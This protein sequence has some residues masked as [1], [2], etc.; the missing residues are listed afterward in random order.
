MFWTLLLAHL[1]GDFVFQTDWMVKKRD[2]FWVLTLH[3]MIHFVTMFIVVGWVRFAIWPYLLLIA[4]WH[5]IQDR[6]KNYFTHKRPT[7]IGM[8]F[9][10]DQG[11]HIFVIWAVIG[12]YQEV[13][14]SIAATDKPRWVMIAITYV[15]ITFV[16]FIIERIFNFSNSEYVQHI[17]KTKFPRMLARAGLVSA[18]LLVWGWTAAGLSF[19]VSNPYP[20][21]RFRRRAVLTDGSVSLVAMGFLFWVLR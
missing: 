11:V 1:L 17:N 2:T 3:A 15:F 19:W 14:G 10:I 4:A 5:F 13:T 9:I 12:L 6:I 21:S 16:W 8:S 20:R 18:Y 7:S